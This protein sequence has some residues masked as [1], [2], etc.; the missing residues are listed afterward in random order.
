MELPQVEVIGSTPLLGSGIDRDKV[1]SETSTLNSRDIRR[2]GTPNLLRALEEQTPGV[3]LDN[4][5]SNPYQPNLFYHGF[6]ASPLQGNAQGLAVY[7]NGVRFNQAFGETVNW[8]LLP[9]IAIDRVDVVGANPAF[10]LNALGGALSVRTKNGFNTQGGDLTLSGGSFGRVQGEFEYGLQRGDVA[11]YVAGTAIHGEG[12]RDQQSSDL[13]NFFGDVGWRGQSSE[14]HLNI[15]AADTNLNGPGTSPVELIAVD[16]ALQF[17][18]PNNIS[19]KYLLISLNGSAELS[20]AT[21]AQGVA[22]YDYFRQRVLNGNVSAFGVCPDGGFLCDEAGNFATDRA[23][24][25]IPDFLSGGPYSQLDQQTTNTNG[26]G[27]SGQITNKT[28]VFGFANQLVVGASYDGARTGFG[29]VSSIGG[30]ALNSRD[31]V[32]PGIPIDQPDGSVA[33]VQVGIS[34]N[35]YGFFLTDTLDL[36]QRLSLNAGGR[37]NAVQINLQDQIGTALNGQ[38]VYNRFNP[39]A[40]LTYRVAPWLTLYGSYAE[41]NRAPTAA[42]LSCADAA[43]PCSLA[44]F[45]V[46]DP[47]L[48]QVVGHTYEAGL[49]G[50]VKPFDG[51]V[52]TWNTGYFHTDLDD[53]ILFTNSPI[54]G[55]AF[56]QNVGSTLRQ[57]LDA[58]VSLKADRWFAYVSYSYIDATFQSGFIESSE[59]NP[60]A[61]ANGNI[62]VRPGDRLPGIPRHLVKFGGSYRVTDK[63][64]VGAS[65]VAASGQVLFG[66]EANLTP[67]TPG[68]FLLNLN[69]SYQLTANVQLFGVVENAANARFYT[70]GTFSPTSAIPIVQAP[71]ATNPRSYSPGPPVG[72]LVGVRATF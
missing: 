38:H 42:E 16:P 34:N 41:S 29:A 71:G 37:F 52:L 57:G 36:T 8:D 68:Y 66:D 23:G 45:F 44:N 9:D 30:L 35:A 40:G 27:V 59:N 17:T 50:R 69:T 10:G 11:T 2:D 12:W 48:K 43:S 18:A 28:P 54:V 63:W 56:F 49:R 21:S 7:L 64:T 20:D 55:R 46:G 24:N 22:Y 3:T 47:N 33:P 53:D 65:A 67:K 6:Q 19:N 62:T 51:T 13:Y 32:G 5:A 25:P 39:N 4:A 60:A 14:L 72:G 26:F 31:F 58:S 61:D 1:P 15:V 70:F